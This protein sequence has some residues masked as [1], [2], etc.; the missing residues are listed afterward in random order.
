MTGV[1]APASAFVGGTSLGPP[2]PSGAPAAGAPGAAGPPA[3]AYRATV[4]PTW[5]PNISAVSRPSTTSPGPVHQ[6][7]ALIGTSS[8]EASGWGRPDM[9]RP[10][11]APPPSAP[12][13][14]GGHRPWPGA[15]GNGVGGLGRGERGVGRRGVEVDDEVRPVRARER[16][17]EGSLGR[18][19]DVQGEG[20]RPAREEQHD[21]E[22][23]GLEPTTAQVGGRLRRDGAHQATSRVVGRSPAIVPSTRWTI[24]WA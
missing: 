15:R 1:R 22:D 16:L 3:A 12:E 5:R 10:S 8:I 19:Q 4:W 7:P 23:S 20:G 9:A 21:G 6:R 17:L 24:R 11:R 2:P 18:D 14:G 13:R